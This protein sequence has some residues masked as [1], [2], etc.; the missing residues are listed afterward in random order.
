MIYVKGT[1]IFFFETKTKMI[2]KTVII[3]I[4]RLQMIYK[5]GFESFMSN[6]N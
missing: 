1:T 2:S 6:F 4:I 5:N 3:V